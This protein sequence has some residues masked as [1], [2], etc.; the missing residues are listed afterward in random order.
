VAATRVAEVA[1]PPARAARPVERPKFLYRRSGMWTVRVGTLALILLGWQLYTRHMQ[2]ALGAP[3]TRIA[4]A[5]FHQMFTTHSIWGPLGSSMEALSLGFLL[6]VAL[7]IPIGIAM[8]RWR[9]VE[10]V[11]DPY[12]SFLYALP[13]VAFVP[14]MV[15]WLG[16][17]LEFR[18]AY[19][20]L[21]A[22]FPVII[23][24]MTGVKNID[25][26]LLAAG[27]SFCASERQI[28]RTIVL[29]A[30][31][32]YMVAG[33]RQ[34]F[35]ASW[36]GVVVAEVLSTQD[37]L[38]GQINHFADYFLTA[39][40]YVPILFIMFIAVVIQWVTNYIQLRLTP[41]SNATQREQGGG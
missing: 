22:I 35:S 23:N 31:S 40:M 5:A 28:L 14:V 32:P 15:F 11:L 8:G 6:S 18:L 39:D 36:V 27:R 38:G 29:P 26:E 37:G 10:H 34:S 2:R 4:R 1:A 9:S 41:W 21:S 25:P 13:H 7:G 12:V 3:P 33:A 16:F 19:V 30:T 24:T 17:R 20:V